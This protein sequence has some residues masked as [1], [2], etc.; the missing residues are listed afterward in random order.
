M[1]SKWVQFSKI[2]PM[3]RSI[4]LE[5]L[6]IASPC[7][8]DWCAMPGDGRKRF[9][10]K[11]NRHVHDLSEYDRA[12]AEAL[13]ASAGC[14]GEHV[15]VRMQRDADGRVMTRDYWKLAAS[16]ALVMG[17]SMTTGCKPAA[18]PNTQSNGPAARQAPLMGHVPASRLFPEAPKP[19]ATP[20]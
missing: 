8:E 12:E 6:H 2:I 1:G 10:S 15:C 7:S 9:C 16:V 19:D 14:R 11:C 4:A 20:K 18:N 3:H 5:Q 13:I 17:A